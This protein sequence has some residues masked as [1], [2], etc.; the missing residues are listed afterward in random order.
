MK[1]EA[2]S[3]L[4]TSSFFSAGVKTEGGNGKGNYCVFPF[5]YKGRKRYSCSLKRRGKVWCATTANYDKDKKWGYCK[6]RTPH[7]QYPRL[8]NISYALVIYK[9]VA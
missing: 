3:T 4:L 8:F 1:N 7:E 5:I 2:P 9:I 6:G